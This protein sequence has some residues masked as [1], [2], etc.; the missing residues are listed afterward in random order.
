M[1]EVDKDLTS[2]NTDWKKAYQEGSFIG[3]IAC[4]ADCILGI[5]SMFHTLSP[6]TTLSRPLP[7][8]RVD[9]KLN[10]D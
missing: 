9:C 2:T 4:H 7:G 8:G 6:N 5:R 1:E 3:T 10:Q